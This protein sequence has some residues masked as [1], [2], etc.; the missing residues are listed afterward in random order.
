MRDDFAE[1]GKIIYSE[2]SGNGTKVVMYDQKGNQ[3]VDPGEANRFWSDTEKMMV[4]LGHTQGT[5]PKPMVTFYTS[6]VTDPEKFQHTRSVL[7]KNNPYDFSFNIQPFDRILEP[8]HFKHLNI[9]ESVQWTG[10]TRSSYYP[11]DQVQVVVKHSRPWNKEIVDQAQRW[12]RIRDIFLY[13]PQGERFRF[14]FKHLAGARAMAQHINQQRHMFDSDGKLIQDLV[15]LLFD[16]KSIQIKC[17]RSN[18]IDLMHQVMDT[19]S[20]I[21]NL[22][23]KMSDANNYSN[24]LNAAKN[25]VGNWARTRRDIQECLDNSCT[26]PEM[27][28]LTE[29][30][31]SF[32]VRDL[33][34]DDA[35]DAE[36]EQMQ[37]AW[38]ASGGDIHDTL[39]YLKANY[40][41]WESRFEEDPE[42]VTQQLEDFAKNSN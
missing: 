8:R 26:T 22:L 29:W 33:F 40:P 18:Q 23:N 16:L 27:K 38:E 9:K 3:T 21:K 42:S 20:Q 41:G 7:K 6:T 31:N 32:E 25:Y 14:P 36:Q 11:V 35:A 1:M 28:H 15:K 24:S 17:S 10:T 5:S 2:L 34:E 37:V 12:R 19:R 30:F 39:D 13:T 4:A